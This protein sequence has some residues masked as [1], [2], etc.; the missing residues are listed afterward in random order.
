MC[1]SHVSSRQWQ[2]ILPSTR[3]LRAYNRQ[4]LRKDIIAGITVGVILVPQGMAYAALA[5]LPAVYGLYAS[6]VPTLIYA[7]LGSSM[8]LSIGPVALSSIIL[9]TGVSGL[10]EPGSQEYIVLA[11]ACAL[12][13]GVMQTLMG[14]SRMGFLLN[15]LSRPVISGF[16]SAAAIIIIFS[17]L[18]AIL[19]INTPRSMY[20]HEVIVGTVERLDQVHLLT[21]GMGVAGIALMA[22]LQRMWNR[23]PAGLVVVLL[24]GLVTG[25]FN[26]EK[27][28]V[29]VVG[30]VKKG[31]PALTLPDFDYADFTKLLPTAL[32]IL[33]VGVIESIAIARAIEARHR[34]YK[35]RANQELIALG[36]SKVLGSLFQ[37]YPTSASFSRSVVNDKVGAVTS[38]SSVISVVLVLLTLLFL[39]PFFAYIPAV[40]LSAIIVVAVAGL[41][42]VHDALELWKT[43][44]SDFVMLI[45]TFVVTLS[46]GIAEGILAGVALSLGYMI[47]STSMPHVS[48]LGQLPG[49]D[50]Y[51]NIKRFP[52]AD[53]RDDVLIV[54]FDDRLYFGNSNVFLD[55]MENLIIARG[56]ALEVFVLDAAGIHYI[57]SSGMEAMKRMIEFV[58]TRDVK[59]YLSGAIGPVRDKLTKSGL[60]DVI[61]THNQFMYVSDA[62][63][64]HVNPPEQPPSWVEQAVQTNIAKKK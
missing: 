6:L 27:L 14:I 18:K 44:R 5:G 17:Q 46:L 25:L 39:T 57:D 21:A 42:H 60:S 28:G 7:L 11:I 61:G 12:I 45:I 4:T 31:L 62:V 63:A 33:F 50:R 2:R 32:A 58:R 40:I 59:F 49:G 29:A 53:V 20:V 37:A 41:I 3:W 51:R 22:V 19:G 47:Y 15:F 38:M 48:V 30:S 9:L 23:L 64:Y 13:V 54:R 35:V 24:A 43:H 26:L 55:T 56:D 34:D 10:A 16:T 52:E 8:H 1:S 36:M